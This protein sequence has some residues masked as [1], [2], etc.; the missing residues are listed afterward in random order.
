MIEFRYA[1]WQN[2]LS[3]GNVPT[4]VE[5]NTHSSTLIIGKNGNGK[6]TILDAL[7]FAL[8][9]KPFRNIT[10]GQ[11]V[12]SINGKNL[13]VTVEFESAGSVYRVVRGIKP[14]LFEIWKNDIL[15]TQDAALKDYQTVLEQQI[16]K[17]TY[18]TFC[19][20]VILG[21]SSFVPFMQLS[22]GNRRE[23]IEDILDIRIFSTMNSL[24]KEKIQLTKQQ[25]DNVS[26]S[27]QI[28][29]SKVNSQQTLI[30]SMMTSKQVHVEGIQ[31]RILKNQ[32]DINTT[33]Q[34]LK[35]IQEK[36]EALQIQIAD[37]PVVH[38]NIA[39]A[40]SMIK[41]IAHNNSTMDKTFRLFDDNDS[42]PS[43]S[44]NIP[45][46]H[47]S[48]IR[49][50]LQ[51]EYDLNLVEIAQLE[52]EIEK[53]TIRMAE[54]AIVAK[55][56][57]ASRNEVYTFTSAIETLNKQNTGLLLDIK[58]TQKDQGNIDAERSKLKEFASTAIDNIA[59]KT[60]LQEQRNIEDIASILLKDTGIKTAV[61]KEYLPMM[62][63][64]INKYLTAMDFFVQFTID[65]SFN[66][67]IKSR[68]RDDF[69]YASFSEGERSRIDLALLF[70]WREIARMKNSAN[71]NLLLLDEVLE[72]S[73]DSAGTEY[74]T[75]L[76]TTL[77]DSCNVFVIS[78]NVESILD[79]FAHVITVE[80]RHDFSVIA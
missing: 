1:Q 62:N 68:Y 56:V 57:I 61:I 20:V 27:I 32:K 59:I 35:H 65:E 7:T 6:S 41:T 70:T 80:K 5:L 31:S 39:H 75:N 17:M 45:H 14:N 36:I 66:E 34:N 30:D 26:T 47:K 55:D 74:I 8:F 71:T 53:C 24:L 42:C 21:S 49:S 37:G 13:L 40:N 29:T 52:Q 79:K 15:I 50:T 10:K 25:L 38:S 58:E 23:V 72:G 46:E 12:N 22:A 69:T 44:Q 2:L 19:Q 18:R 28:A 76:L 11:L 33:E 64:L 73:L 16:L 63:T 4:R 67:S 78:H 9:N 48:T 51:T 60:V 43:C 54:V 3:T 77:G